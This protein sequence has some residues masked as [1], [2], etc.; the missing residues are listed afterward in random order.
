M[1][2]P[3]AVAAPDAI[4]DGVW[5]GPSAQVPVA[6]WMQQK[7]GGDIV[8]VPY[9]AF[10]FVNDK[11]EIIG[12]AYFYNHHKRQRADITMAVAFDREI[13]EHPG[14]FRTA[15]KRVLS[16]P[17]GELNLPRVTAEIDSTNTDSIDLAQRCGFVHEGTKRMAGRNGADVEIYG[18]YRDACPFLKD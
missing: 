10:G 8:E 18:L 12:G 9:G 11:G 13:A 7:L 16:F 14:A 15:I 2:D 17:F 4:V 5:G 6:T 3:I 1:S